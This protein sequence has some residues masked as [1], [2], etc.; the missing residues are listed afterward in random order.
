LE[1]ARLDVA[2]RDAVTA[3]PIFVDWTVTCEHSTNFPR[4][5]ARSNKDGLAAAQAVDKKRTRY[6]PEGIEL[7]PAAL[8]SGGRPADE[9]VALIRSY[10][11]GLPDA[12]RSVIISRTWRQL[13]RT[14]QIGN[15]EM[16]L[17]AM[18]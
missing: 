1:E 4:R 5:R 16:I 2:T 10:G 3:Q 12:E 13:S 7:V 15:A 14:L 6:P 9:L 18:G 8:E 11:H 17:S